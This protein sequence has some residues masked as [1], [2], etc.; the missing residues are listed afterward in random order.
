MI[1][2]NVIH[3]NLG[4]RGVERKDE[5]IHTGGESNKPVFFNLRRKL[6][7]ILL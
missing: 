1:I 2:Y 3:S 6:F 5:S 4:V 7:F